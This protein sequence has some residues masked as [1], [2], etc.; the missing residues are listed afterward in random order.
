MLLEEPL[1][2]LHTSSIPPNVLF[3]L[4]H[5]DKT[6]Y[7]SITINLSSLLIAKV[8]ISCAV[9]TPQIKATEF[10]RKTAKLA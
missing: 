10:I 9:L 6:L 8:P 7:K 5:F 3:A 1:Q 2:G 4:H